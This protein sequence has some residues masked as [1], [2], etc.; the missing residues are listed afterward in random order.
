LVRCGAFFGL[1]YCARPDGLLLG[2]LAVVAA[3]VRFDGQKSLRAAAGP[4]LR[5]ALPL[6]LVA[7]PY[8]AFQSVALGH[9]SLETKSAVNYA[10][11]SRMLAGAGYIEAADGL[12]PGLREDGAELGPGFYALHPGA[13]PPSLAQRLGF[14]RRVGV[15]QLLALVRAL[16]APHNGSPL[17]LVLAAVGLCCGPRTGRRR[18]SDP[19]LAVFLAANFVALLSLAHFWARYAAPF[20]PFVVLWAAAGIDALLGLLERR[21]PV[22]APVALRRIESAIAIVSCVAAFTAGAR[23][24]RS[25]AVD[26]RPLKAAARWLDD[27]YPGPKLTMAIS[28][29]VPFYARGTWYPLPWASSE[30]AAAYVRAKRPAFVV[31]EPRLADRSY[32]ADWRT[33]GIPGTAARLVYTSPGDAETAVEVLKL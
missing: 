23:D 8:V 15:R 28:D 31:L 1:A 20:V 27:T 21:A 26:P 11:G 22:A 24:F 18:I 30:N 33:H 14:A 9:F 6:A 10:L 17:V 2:G 5:V 16:G 3:A 4:A 19:A 25:A 7:A 32:L 12:G 13:R 29:I